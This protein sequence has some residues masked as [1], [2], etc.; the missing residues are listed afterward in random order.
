[1]ARNRWRDDGDSLMIAIRPATPADAGDILRLVRALAAYER[2]PE[3]VAMDAAGCQAALFGDGAV[4]HA[5]VAE[6]D[7]RI[8]GVALWF[9]NFSTW[10]G[11]PGLYL[12]DLYVDEDARGAGAGRALL[13]ALAREAAARGCARMEWSVLD[14]NE[15]AM[16]FY[17]RIGAEAKRGWQIWRLDGAALAALAV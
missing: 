11:R 8:V 15:P 9:L 4:A 13:T 17:R 10:T 12:E 6:A 14:W 2:E 16:G 3:A 7:G 1:M 5:H